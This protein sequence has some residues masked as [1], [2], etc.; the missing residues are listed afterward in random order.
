MYTPF[1]HILNVFTFNFS[2]LCKTTN[3]HV[4]AGFSGAKKIWH[5]RACAEWICSTYWWTRIKWG[6]H[7]QRCGWVSSIYV[8]S[9]PVPT[10]N[11]TTGFPF[12]EEEGNLFKNTWKELLL[13]ILYHFEY[14]MPSNLRYVQ[15]LNGGLREK[16]ERF[17]MVN[18]SSNLRCIS[19]F[20]WGK[21]WKMCVLYLKSYDISAPPTHTH[22]Y[23]CMHIHIPFKSK[24]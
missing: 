7:V 9:V 17:I 5:G 14:K 21:I 23:E 13:Y 16:L 2:S 1:R 11:D 20:L 22:T 15:F 10:D 6:H 12:L 19:N 3:I 18:N 4:S 8:A 24:H